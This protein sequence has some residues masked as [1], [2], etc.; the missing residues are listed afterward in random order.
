MSTGT[1]RPRM[2]E[3]PKQMPD[4][5][6]KR[7]LA[8]GLVGLGCSTVV[9][10]VLEASAPATQEPLIGTETIEQLAAQAF[11]CPALGEAIAT[12]LDARFG[13]I[14]VDDMQ[15]LHAQAEQ[16]ADSR[17]KIPPMLRMHSALARLRE[18]AYQQAVRQEQLP[19]QDGSLSLRLSSSLSG[20]T[21]STSQN[22]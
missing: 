18:V 21:N 9:L 15:S 8:A 5:V 20:S 1:I 7:A 12:R 11:F 4:R 14:G 6:K 17:S 19:L 3:T 10:A 16:C 22:K 2:N 13:F